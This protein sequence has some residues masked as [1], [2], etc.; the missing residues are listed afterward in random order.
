[1]QFTYIQSYTHT[2]TQIKPFTD[3]DLYTH[4][5]DCSENWVLILVAAK[6]SEMTI[7]F[8]LV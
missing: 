2:H 5:N 7:V 4:T 8:S 6:Y 3:I 1:M